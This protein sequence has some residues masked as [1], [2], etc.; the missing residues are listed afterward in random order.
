M[1]KKEIEKIIEYLNIKGSFARNFK[2]YSKMYAMTTENISGFLNKHDVNDK[3][4]LTVAGSG[5]QRYNCYLRGAKEVVCFDINPLAE[6]HVRLKDTAIEKLEYEDF[7]KFFGVVIDDKGNCFFDKS[8]FNKFKDGLDED[9]YLLYDFIINKFKADPFK[10][11][12]HDYNCDYNSMI[13]FD[14]Y[15]IKSNFEKLKGIMKNKDFRFLN[16]NVAYLPETLN[17]EKFDM[18]LLSNI[19]DYIDLVYGNSHMK[20]YRELIDHL[21]DNLYDDGIIQVGY[22]YNLYGVGYTDSKF[23]FPESRNKVFPFTEYPVEFVPSFNNPGTYDKVIT[24]K[25]K[26]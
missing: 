1:D 2:G 16:T 26:R 21:V 20:D 10:R 18:I 13:E 7:L 9:V 8:I 23:R 17:G 15:I 22:I 3:K 6:L 14:D 12:Y 11:A 25:K 4:V 24:Y 19:S 5:D